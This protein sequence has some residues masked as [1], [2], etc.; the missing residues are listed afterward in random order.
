MG[1]KA[2]N[3]DLYVDDLLTE[4]LSLTQMQEQLRGANL[5]PA[6]Y[7]Q[8]HLLFLVGLINS[9]QDLE[10]YND[11][12]SKIKDK[13][14]LSSLLSVSV[15]DRRSDKPTIDMD[16]VTRAL[17][18]AED[19]NELRSIL[20]GQKRQEQVVQSTYDK[21]ALQWYLA[22]R[23]GIELLDILAKLEVKLD[24]ELD[25]F[26]AEYSRKA[27]EVKE[28]LIT[29]AQRAKNIQDL[30]AILHEGE[31]KNINPF[32]STTSLTLKDLQDGALYYNNETHIYI[33]RTTFQDD[34]VKSIRA[35][36]KYGQ[37][38]RFGLCI[39]SRSENYYAGYRTGNMG[40]YPLTTYFV[41]SL[42]DKS[43]DPSDI[44]NYE[45]AIVDAQTRNGSFS[46]N[47]V[48]T[49]ATRS[50]KDIHGHDGVTWTFSNED[51]GGLGPYSILDKLDHIFKNKRELLGKD[52]S[53]YTL[54]E[55]NFREIFE[56]IPLGPKE[57]KIQK[58]IRN[59]EPED[60][61]AFS[62]SEKMALV[63]DGELRSA[64][65]HRGVF[66]KLSPEVR[67][68]IV[69]LT[70]R[71]YMNDPD[72]VGDS[73]Y[74]KFTDA[75]KRIYAKTAIKDIKEEL[76]KQLKVLANKQGGK[77]PDITDPKTINMLVNNSG[78]PTLSL[79]DF[80]LIANDEQLKTIY[81]DGLQ[82]NNKKIR[83]YVLSKVDENGVYK[84]TLD[85]TSGSGIFAYEDFFIPKY[86]LPDL[87]DIVINGS[88]DVYYMNLLSLKG[89]PKV[90]ENLYASGN[91]LPNLEGG[92]I[93]AIKYDVSSSSLRNLLG[94]PKYVYEFN[95]SNNMLTSLKGCP[96]YV[97][98]DFMMDTNPIRSLEGIPKMI[99]GNFAMYRIPEK[100]MRDF[101]PSS[102]IVGRDYFISGNSYKH[103][104]KA[105]QLYK[106]HELRDNF[107]YDKIE[108][109]KKQVMS[110]FKTKKQAGINKES[111][112]Y[113]LLKSYL[114][115][116]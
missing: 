78:G 36:L 33:I 66:E 25:R 63:T 112:V 70:D 62:D 69:K 113:S 100:L 81:V 11:L 71:S 86:F 45:I 2:F 20:S 105:P 9:N 67:M 106:V 30:I 6:K 47:P 44:N 74:N 27:E 26:I 111:A 31:T 60:F 93:A 57:Q 68:S 108:E 18:H 28:Y 48:A 12:L 91:M 94:A 84:G 38:N 99:G 34:V 114:L 41:Y 24:G 1:K 43:A 3:F 75:E 37:G 16:K 51:I 116:S 110:D 10:I 56:Y 21:E 97:G 96:E 46:Y 82:A 52:G 22:K 85:L 73:V 92:P 14:L 83:D 19:P 35:N 95:I 65:L 76:A 32:N 29:N 58:L 103:L 80:S 98:G 115:S 89:C 53:S 107:L 87:S 42:H 49:V 61:L 102:I 109:L 23:S 54:D 4:A 90:V 101:D 17:Q 79:L 88:L 39:S 50:K 15:N 104:L 55:Y 8:K 7:D 72:I 40:G 5:D 59:F 64:V 77:E 13:G